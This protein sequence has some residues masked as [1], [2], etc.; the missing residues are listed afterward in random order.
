M[1]TLTIA[2]VESVG[3]IGAVQ[4]MFREYMAWTNTLGFDSGAAPT[5]D[6]FE[7]EVA[8]LPGIYAPPRGRLL[9]A[10]AGGEPAGCVALRPHDGAVCELKRLYV[11][12]AFR[13]RRVGWLLVERLLDEARRLGY[14]RMVLDSHR[15]MEKAHQIY[16]AHGF[17]TVAAPSDFPEFLRP[18]VVFMECDL[19]PSRL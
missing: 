8:T 11:R 16:H 6:G 17:R 1:S 14:T 13:G 15:S 4:V 10:R 12:P 9:L 3:D 19:V 5:F 18:I 2:Q 7:D